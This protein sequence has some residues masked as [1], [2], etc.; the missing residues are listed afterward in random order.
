MLLKLRICNI[1]ANITKSVA[2]N[3]VSLLVSWFRRLIYHELCLLI[4]FIR[5]QIA[6]SRILFNVIMTAYK[7]SSPSSDHTRIASIGPIVYSLRRFETS[8]SARSSEHMS[9]STATLLPL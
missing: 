2:I 4:L 9:N 6:I 7:H 1:S 3:A 8:G 5:L